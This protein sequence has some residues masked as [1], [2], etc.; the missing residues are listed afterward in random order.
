MADGQQESNL[1]FSRLSNTLLA[2]ATTAVF[3]IG[4]LFFQNQ[5][6]QTEMRTEITNLKTTFVEF[7][8][9]LREQQIGFDERLR[10]VEQ[11]K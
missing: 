9:N 8:N 5:L 1:I 11:R 7:R 4:S 2:I 10:T 6:A 3:A